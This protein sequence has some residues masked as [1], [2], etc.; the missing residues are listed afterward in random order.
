MPVLGEP[1]PQVGGDL[2]L[3]QGP[4]GDAS[5]EVRAQVGQ[6]HPLRGRRTVLDAGDRGGDGPVLGG[7]DDV[8]RAAHQQAGHQA[9]LS[10]GREVVLHAEGTHARPERDRGRGR[11]LRLE[12]AHRFDR[13]L[14]RQFAPAQ[15]VLPGEGG[16]V[17]LALGD[18]ALDQ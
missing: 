17:Q 8:E 2:R 3:R 6:G 1:L 13:G 9:P 15:Q 7:A 18:R 5:L 12:G 11:V 4:L 14:R 10:Q 16:A